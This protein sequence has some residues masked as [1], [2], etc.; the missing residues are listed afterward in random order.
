MI[1]RPD[2]MGL[3]PQQKPTA[4]VGPPYL[5]WRLMDSDDHF[6]RRAV[7]TFLADLPEDRQKR[8]REWSA[9]KPLSIQVDRLVIDAMKNYREPDFLKGRA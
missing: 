7:E 8:F 1:K 9:D 6:R 2:A 3:Q 4:R 5:C